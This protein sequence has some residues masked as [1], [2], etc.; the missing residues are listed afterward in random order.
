[1]GSHG[2]FYTLDS[3]GHKKYTISYNEA[4]IGPRN[5]SGNQIHY[6]SKG[7]SYIVRNG[8][9]VYS[10]KPVFKQPILNKV[11]KTMA[12][13][14]IGKTLAK[15]IQSKKQPSLN[16]VKKTVAGAV[17]GKTLAKYI[18]SKKPVTNKKGTPL[19][20]TSHDKYYKMS[21]T[22]KSKIYV[23]DVIQPPQFKLKPQVISKNVIKNLL[24]AGYTNK[25]IEHL[26]PMVQKTPSNVINKVKKTV[27]GAVIG[28]TLAKYIQSKKPVTNKKGTPLVKTS[29][30][31]Y[32]KMSKTGKSK[33]YVKDVIQPPQ[34]KLK[35][36]K[37]VLQ[38]TNEQKKAAGEKIAHFVSTRFYDKLLGIALKR[39]KY[40]W[41]KISREITG[42]FEP[43]NPGAPEN[44]AKYKKASMYRKAILRYMRIHKWP[45]AIWRGLGDHE[46]DKITGN[47]GQVI[48]TK[49]FS[50]FSRNRSIAEAFAAK[51]KASKIF[52]DSSLVLRIGNNVSVPAVQYYGSDREGN[53]KLSKLVNR[54]EGEDEVLLPPG[55]FKIVDIRNKGLTYTVLEV[56]FKPDYNPTE[57][58]LYD[59]LDK[60]YKEFDSSVKPT[61]EYKSPIFHPTVNSKG[62]FPEKIW[63]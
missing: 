59:S 23:K 16:K 21:K 63:H 3:S 45:R 20:K 55:K 57:K 38:Y 31:K 56:D 25:E 14:V 37:T 15:Y 52:G 39:Q 7:G 36:K 35:S 33:I 10:I 61:K 2:A 54:Y 47:I 49:S 42:D 30:D 41:D 19:V 62:M 18:Q 4:N 40:K 22:G 8:K 32:Y 60:K 58:I 13:A 29:H 1:M 51:A 27:A 50:Q 34:F 28:K 26:M 44:P 11:K 17:I 9:K 46:V 6:G 12:G 43:F 53:K 24:S 48:E 5:I